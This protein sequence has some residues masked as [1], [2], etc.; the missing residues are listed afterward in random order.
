MLYRRMFDLPTWRFRSSFEEL[1]RIRRQMDRL[2]GEFTGTPSP[3]TRA[4]VFPLINLTE[5]QDSYHVRA[6]LPGVK[7]AELDIQAT[8]N[9][10]AISGERKIPVE[11]E[12]ARY[13]RRER[14]A[15]KFSR[16]IALPGDIDAD[17]IDARLAHGVL[18]VT[19]PKAEA[20]KPRRISVR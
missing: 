13:H 4:G 20:V 19:V 12:G 16:I 17:K 3:R 11:E 9:N 2:L 5:D 18:T 6:E 15:G 14:E 10:V 7:A 8:G 1:E